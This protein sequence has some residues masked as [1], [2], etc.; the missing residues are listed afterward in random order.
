M[1]QRSALLVSLKPFLSQAWGSLWHFRDSLEHQSPEN[2]RLRANLLLEPCSLSSVLL[3]RFL[4]SGP[5]SP[6]RFTLPE[7]PNPAV[8]ERHQESKVNKQ[9]RPKV[10]TKLN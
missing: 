8:S 1:A 5:L 3:G 7:K 4:V 9:A 2:S 6:F 10:M